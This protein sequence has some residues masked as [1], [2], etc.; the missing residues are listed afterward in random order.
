MKN[1]L[2][3]ICPLSTMELF[4]QRVFGKD[5]FFLT[6]T[7]GVFQNHEYN[8]VEGIKDFILRQDIRSIIFVNDL[9]CPLIDNILRHQ[10][11]FG[12]ESEKVLENIYIDNYTSLLKGQALPDQKYM[13]AELNIKK[14]IIKLKTSTVLGSLIESRKIEVSGLI[15]FRKKNLIQKIISTKKSDNKLSSVKT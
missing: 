3:I 2:Y 9:E 14:Q 5:I 15:T 1:K 12:L 8:Y 6:A 10:N 7:G 13:L 11:L 4:L